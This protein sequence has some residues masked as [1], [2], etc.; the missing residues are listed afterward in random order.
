MSP[1][2]EAILAS[3]LYPSTK[4]INVWDLDLLS[5]FCREAYSVVEEDLQA[6]CQDRAISGQQRK[7]DWWQ[8]SLAF[9]EDPMQ[10]GDLVYHQGVWKERR[11]R[12]DKPGLCCTTAVVQWPRGHVPRF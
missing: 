1:G 6:S 10:G 2:A 8:L 11:H 4:R 9:E 7:M 3:P 12:P 5:G